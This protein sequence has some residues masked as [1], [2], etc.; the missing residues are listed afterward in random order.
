MNDDGGARIGCALLL[1]VPFSLVLFWLF[2]IWA[3]HHV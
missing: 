3:R 1:G 2:V